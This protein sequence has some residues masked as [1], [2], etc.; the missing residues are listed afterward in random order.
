M[1]P[2]SI[3]GTNARVRKKVTKPTIPSCASIFHDF[4]RGRKRMRL[5]TATIIIAARHDV[6]IYL[7]IGVRNRSVAHTMSHVTTDEKLVFAPAFKFTAVLENEPATPYPP[8]KPEVIF[9]SHCPISSLF[10]ETRCFVL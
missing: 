2:V 7:S 3:F 9:A 5:I 6:G 8:K 10:A 4:I 1:I